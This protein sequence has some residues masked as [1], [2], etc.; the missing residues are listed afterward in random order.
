MREN[1]N[2]GVAASP[3]AA[4]ATDDSLDKLKNFATGVYALYA[5]SVLFGVT[6]IV[7]IVIAY[8]KRSEAKGTWLE[9]H[10]QWQIRTFW[11]SLLWGF[12]GMVVS[13]VACLVG[14]ISISSMSAIGMV[15]SFSSAGFMILV[16]A[17]IAI[18][19]IYRV[20]KGWIR[21]ADRKQ[22]YV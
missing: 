15:G 22:M 6:S 16:W 9:T 19:F 21:L 10:F 12:L 2:P 11:Y 7:G 18:W 13:A 8:L 5:A 1:I 20:V 14:V 3:A 4:V 17:C